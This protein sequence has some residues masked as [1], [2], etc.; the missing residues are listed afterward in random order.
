M[1]VTNSLTG[2]GAE[3]SI[4][5]VSNELT[6]RGWPVAL[7]PINSGPPD[8]IVPTCESFPLERPWRGGLL[9]TIFA[10]RKFHQVVR[11][12]EPDVVVLNCDLPELFGAALSGSPTVVVLEHSS[13]PWVQR[14]LLGRI[15]RLL[16]SLRKPHW[17]AVSSHLT[18]WPK[19][20]LPFAILQNPLIATRVGKGEMVE[21]AVPRLVFV[22]RLSAEKNPGLALE[23]SR[24]TEIRLE[25]FGAGSLREELEAESHR[26]NLPVLFHGRVEDPWLYIRPTDLL[27]VPSQYEGDGLV[28]I[29]GMREGIPMLLSDIPDFR[30]FGFP[31]RNYCKNIAEFVERIERFKNRFEDLKIPDEIVRE[32][33]SSRSLKVVGD[34]WE[35]LLTKI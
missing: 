13:T 32:T 27:L 16:L 3:R 24:L 6:H 28:V 33:L 29:E 9:S 1:F 11:Q 10:M 14:V 22:G 26:E 4:N 7:V 12:W 30:R 15:V 34:S 19:S 31:E 8:Q 23:T 21:G 17:V 25:I 20:S 2:G 18:I 35:T 5:L